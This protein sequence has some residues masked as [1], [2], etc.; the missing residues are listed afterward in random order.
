MFSLQGHRGARALFPENTLEGIRATIAMGVG[1]IEIDVGVTRDGEVVVHHDPA[2]NPDITRDGAGVWLD[3]PGPLL[4]DLTLKQ[5]RAFDVGRIRPDTSYAGRF[6]GQAGQDGVRVPTLAQVL[7]LEGAAWTIELKLLP[8]QPEWTVPPE[9][10][11]ERVLHV[12][13][14]AGALEHVTI[15]SFDWRAPRHARRIRPSVARAW[16]TAP[17]ALAD[18]ILWMGRDIAGVADVPRAIAAEG[19]G[20]WTPNHRSLDET[21]LRHAQELGLTVIPWTVN[22]PADMR[23]LIG[24]GVDGIITDRP[25]LGLTALA[26]RPANPGRPASSD[27][28]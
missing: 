26:E 13:S 4:R 22:D 17:E 3:S 15:Q 28:G 24:W 12:A 20:T 7:T 9:D 27:V 25:D 10:M 19:G 1:A 14:A 11:V 18:P 16:L 2:L 5:L 6:P 23:R 21:L 8:D